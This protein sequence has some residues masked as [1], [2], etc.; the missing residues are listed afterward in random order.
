MLKARVATAILLAVGLLAVLF[1]L[2]SAAVAGVFA[3]V[4]SL[5]AWEWAGLL[6]RSSA[7]RV[8]FAVLMAISCA[9]ASLLPSAHFLLVP[10]VC[11]WLVLAPFWLWR[12]WSL[13]ERPLL[14]LL[15]GWLLLLATWLSMVALHGAGAWVLLAALALVWVADIAAYFAGRAFGRRKLAPAI[16]P[17]KTWEGVVGALLAVLLYGFAAARMLGMPALAAAPMAFLLV[18]LTG[19]SIEGDLLES[20]LKR[21]SGLKDSSNLLPGHGGV[22]DRIDSQLSTLPLLALLLHWG[23]P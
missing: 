14:G 2:P 12:R 22:L 3:L 9:G 4:A 10:V 6:G 21:Q 15:F 13:A 23:N 5:A 19:V 17:G 20:L 7:Q 11:F 16:S 1:L 18:L 8:A